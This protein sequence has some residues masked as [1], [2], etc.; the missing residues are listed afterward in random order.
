MDART[1]VER[2]DA[3]GPDQLS[4][5][6]G[7]SAARTVLALAQGRRPE[8]LSRLVDPARPRMPTPRLSAALL[9]A[10][11]GQPYQPRRSD[12]RAGSVEHPAAARAAVGEPT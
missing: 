12:G 1:R 4:S 3:V 11:D 10:S 7:I 5:A 8:R 6:A 9:A 2:T